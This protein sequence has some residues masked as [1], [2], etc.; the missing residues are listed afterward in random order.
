MT[1]AMCRAAAIEKLRFVTDDPVFET[2]QLLALSLGRPLHELVAIR[3][4][5]IDEAARAAFEAAVERRR[6]HEPL[7]YICGEWEFFGL[8]MYCGEGCLIPRPE[9]E[10]LCELAVKHLP[11]RGR[12]LDLCTGSGCIA[13]AVLNN[14]RDVTAAAVD[15]SEQ[16]LVYARRNAEAH[17]VSDRLTVV[18]ADLAEYVPDGKI[19]VLTANPPYIK[20]DDIETLSDEVRHEPRLALDGGADGLMFYR[21]IA[22][23][24]TPYL[25]ERGEMLLEVGYDTAEGVAELF[26]RANFAVGLYPDRFGVKRVCRARKTILNP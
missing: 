21:A 18:H 12:M 2:D 25:A 14:R 19:D 8:K 24:Y 16:A 22:A 4:E 10:T 17:A 23:R 9:T 3:R 5:E 13:V 26:R 20:T 11:R 7:Q 6:R 1:V 15:V